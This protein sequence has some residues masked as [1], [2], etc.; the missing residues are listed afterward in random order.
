G[1]TVACYIKAKASGSLCGYERKW[2][3][4]VLTEYFA[5][6]VESGVIGKSATMFRSHVG[7]VSDVVDKE[8]AES[9]S[10]YPHKDLP[11]CS[12]NFEQLETLFTRRRS[13]RW[14]QDKIVPF[15]LVQKAAN[16]A[17]LAPSACNRQPYKFIVI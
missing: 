15:D 12:V 11:E 3:E 5:V 1:E 7:P 8:L 10:P 13:V 9:Y 16:I 14:Y 6:V 17:T 4:D 2:A